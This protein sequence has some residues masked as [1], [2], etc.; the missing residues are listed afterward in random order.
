MYQ[1]FIEFESGNIDGKRQIRLYIIYVRIHLQ[2]LR[3]LLK[4]GFDVNSTDDNK[5]TS[6]HYLCMNPY[7]NKKDLCLLLSASNSL[8]INLADM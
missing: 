6:L 4:S 8:Q 3:I 5:R 7:I 2:M 1:S